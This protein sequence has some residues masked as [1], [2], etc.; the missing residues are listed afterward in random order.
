MLNFEYYSPTRLVVGRQTEKE[1]GRLA[2]QYGA[3]KVLVH[4]G[5][6]SV[7]RSGLLERVLASLS[8]AGLP[9]VTLG[10][11]VPNPLDTLVY[12]GITLCKNEGV[13]FVLGVGGGSAIDSAKAIAIGACDNGDFWDFY[14]RKREPHHRLGLGTIMTLPATGSE[15]SNSSVIKRSSEP[16]KRGL[17]SDLNRPDFSIINPELTFTLPPYQTACGASDILSHV[18]ERYFSHTT[19]VSLTD[20]L[21]EA[22]MQ[23]VLAEAPR[24]LADPT[25]YDAQANLFWAS[26]Q[27]HIGLMGMGRQED[28]SV[29]ALEHELS[30]GYDTAHGAGLAVLYPAWLTYL[31]PRPA[32]TMLIAQWAV[33]VMGVPMDFTSPEETGR[34]GVLRLARTFADWGLPTSLQALGVPHDDLPTLTSRTKRNPDGSCGFFGPLHDDDILAI[35]EIAWNGTL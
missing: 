12:E 9:Y 7:N 33:R 26:T 22:V 15:A 3:T 18:M 29:H 21:C 16:L 32:N 25:D 11:V 34:A 5:S 14:V 31:L 23:T 35:Y 20:R 30:G 19:G 6:G 27:A 8:Q 10:G 13:D 24:A 2:R 1:A 4:Y 28:W 17:R